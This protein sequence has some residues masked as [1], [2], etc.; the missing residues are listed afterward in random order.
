MDEWSLSS[1][2]DTPRFSSTAICRRNGGMVFVGVNVLNSRVE[3]AEDS[4][5]NG[6]VEDDLFVM[7]G[8]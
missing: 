3:E 1:A 5:S 8:E 4:R 7:A 2:F 6:A